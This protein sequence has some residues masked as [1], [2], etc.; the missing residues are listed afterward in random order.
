ML[1]SIISIAAFELVLNAVDGKLTLLLVKHAGLLWP[2]GSD[3]RMARK[4]YRR[5]EY[6]RWAEARWLQSQRPL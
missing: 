5:P 2:L 1:L 3:I 4:T 6:V